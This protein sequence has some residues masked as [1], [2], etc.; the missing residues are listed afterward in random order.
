MDN[1]YYNP[2][3]QNQV[4]W[5]SFG[6]SFNGNPIRIQTITPPSS[7]DVSVTSTPAENI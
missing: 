5:L 3:S 4:F 6:G 1:Q 2:Y 7:Y